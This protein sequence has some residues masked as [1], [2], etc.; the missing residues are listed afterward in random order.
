MYP[1]KGGPWEHAKGDRKWFAMACSIPKC[2]CCPCTNSW[3]YRRAMYA[4][5]HM[6]VLCFLGPS[7]PDQ[8]PLVPPTPIFSRGCV[9]PWIQYQ[10]QGVWDSCPSLFPKTLYHAC[11]LARNTLKKGSFTKQQY[12]RDFT[13]LPDLSKAGWPFQISSFLYAIPFKLLA[14]WHLSRELFLHFYQSISSF[15]ANVI[16]INATCK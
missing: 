8:S 16:S 13:S 6:R 9:L 3:V 14:Y 7:S 15:W 11:Y 12:S 5:P 10:E 1:C 4:L 2:F